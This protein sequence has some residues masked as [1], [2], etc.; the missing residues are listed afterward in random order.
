[1]STIRTCTLELTHVLEFAKQRCALGE[2]L[3]RV[4][5]YEFRHPVRVLREQGRDGRAIS[6]DISEVGIGLFAPFACDVGER[7]NLRLTIPDRGMMEHS[8]VVT[9]VEEIGRGL[10]ELGCLFRRW[11]E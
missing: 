2:I 11:A 4:A 7:V 9:R 1:M 3:R 8:A 10:W 6:Y 5:R